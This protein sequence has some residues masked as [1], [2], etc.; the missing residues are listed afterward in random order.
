MREV[1]MQ[2]GDVPGNVAMNPPAR[3]QPTRRPAAAARRESVTADDLNAMVLR[4]QGGAAPQTETE[5]RLADRMGIAYRKGGLVAPKKYQEGGP[6]KAPGKYTRMG[7]AKAP[8]PRM[9][10]MVSP[11]E[12]KELD[13][14]LTQAEKNRL[15]GDNFKKGGK[16]VA[17]KMKTGGKVPAPKK[18]MKGG[19]TSKPKV[20]PKM[21]AK[22]GM[23]KGCK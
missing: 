6:V 23:T 8:A 18:M 5:R 15:R 4:L 3:P 14:P 9:R 19:I 16:V 22:G 10:D 1:D 17:K 12:R 20:K 7:G 2:G 11:E 21:Y 13:A